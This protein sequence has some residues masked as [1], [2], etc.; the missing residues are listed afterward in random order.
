MLA[1]CHG[2]GALGRF[3]FV[4]LCG[5]GGLAGVLG[6]GWMVG[7]FLLGP[8]PWGDDGVALEWPGF[9]LGYGL[10]KATCGVTV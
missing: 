1:G 9:G 2:C 5:G 8:L 7:V 10:V 6:L 4:A 3:S